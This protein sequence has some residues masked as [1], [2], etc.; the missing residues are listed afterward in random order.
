MALAQ[1]KA[2]ITH[3]MQKPIPEEESLSISEI[4]SRRFKKNITVSHL[5]TP[6]DVA[7]L[8]IE[9]PELVNSE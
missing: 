1:E 3:L 8:V 9:S 5:T 6:E 2:D 4:I 7:K